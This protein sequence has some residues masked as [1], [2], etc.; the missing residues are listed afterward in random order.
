MADQRHGGI[1]WTDETWNPIRGCS[2]V[3]AGCENCYAEKMAARFAWPGTVG[4][5]GGSGLDPEP[6]GPFADVING[7]GKWNG[8]VEVLPN[9]LRR[10]E[11]WRRPRRVFVNSMSDLFHDKVPDAFI[12]RVFSVMGGTPQHTYQILTKRPERAL[13]M[14]SGTAWAAY[15]TLSN[16][17][18]GVSVENQEAAEQRIPLLLQMPAA[19]RFAS[20]EPLIG[21]VDLHN[22]GG[23]RATAFQ[24]INKRPRRLDWVICGG[25][26]GD[27]ARPMHPDWARGLRDQ[28]AGAGVPF[29]FKQWGTWR[30][31]TTPANPNAKSATIRVFI[32]GQ[33]MIKVGKKAAG[34][35][36]DGRTWDEF[37]EQ[38][39]LE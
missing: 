10:P 11:S 30:P 17:W 14:F 39:S 7:S 24:M 33:T 28:C 31:G 6:S 15:E 32:G 36:L 9:V 5:E 19:V 3:S 37:P 13:K 16:V 20:C 25:E 35:T 23:K 18:I 8:H 34:R 26:S 22:V 38:R 21:P 4:G 1:A 29:M 2:K 12:A 27:D